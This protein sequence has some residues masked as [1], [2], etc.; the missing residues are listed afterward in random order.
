MEPEFKH[1]CY[2]TYFC[3]S[4]VSKNAYIERNIYIAINTKKIYVPALT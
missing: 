4:R 2:Q 3:L 1:L